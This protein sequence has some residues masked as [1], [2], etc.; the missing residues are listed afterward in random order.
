MRWDR[1]GVMRVGACVSEGTAECLAPSRAP[2]GLCPDPHTLTPQVPPARSFSR[3]CFKTNLVAGQGA[4]PLR[5]AAAAAQQVLH[6]TAVG[7]RP[8][9]QQ[10][11]KE[12]KTMVE[13]RPKVTLLQMR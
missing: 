7:C 3:R 2:L 12:P 11:G 10:G 13:G 1:G 4:E 6:R 5:A 8:G 9:R